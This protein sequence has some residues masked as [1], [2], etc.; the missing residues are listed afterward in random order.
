MSFVVYTLLYGLDIKDKSESCRRQR[1]RNHFVQC[2][3]TGNKVQVI[4]ITFGRECCN[5]CIKH[6]N[7]QSFKIDS[8]EILKKISQSE[9]TD[10]VNNRSPDTNILLASQINYL[11]TIFY[12]SSF[13]ELTCS[14]RVG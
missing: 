1:S 14:V 3:F 7:L 10:R 4:L 9:K 2:I 8:A 12:I 5:Y 6:L 11:R 13:I